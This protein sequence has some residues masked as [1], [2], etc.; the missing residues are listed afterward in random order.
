MPRQAITF[1]SRLM[2]TPEAAVYLGVSER[3]T[4]ELSILPK[5]LGS[6]CRYDR[7]SLGEYAS[8][9][10]GGGDRDEVT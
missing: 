8:N 4:W 7:L 9:L 1:T 5:L 10:F 2:Q 6:K 3:M